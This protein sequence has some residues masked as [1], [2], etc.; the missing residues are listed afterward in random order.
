MFVALRPKGHLPSATES[1]YCS[2][3]VWMLFRMFL[4]CL[5]GGNFGKRDFFRGDFAEFSA[6]VEPLLLK[7]LPEFSRFERRKVTLH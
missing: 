1:V 7:V 4:N 5:A 2:C 6:E 3:L